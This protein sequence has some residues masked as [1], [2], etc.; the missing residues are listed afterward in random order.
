MSTQIWWQMSIFFVPAV[1]GREKRGQF[2]GWMQNWFGTFLKNIIFWIFY[3]W[4]NSV[5]VLLWIAIN[6]P[7]CFCNWNKRQAVWFNL[8]SLLSLIASPWTLWTPF[9]R[10]WWFWIGWIAR[11]WTPSQIDSCQCI[12]LTQIYWHSL[13]I[14]KIYYYIFT[15]HQP[16]RML[17]DQSFFYCS[18]SV[19]LNTHNNIL[20]YCAGTGIRH[21]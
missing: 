8:L 6:I 15:Q 10:L 14:D 5:C 21:T 9:E 4:L 16:T 13:S 3:D 20:Q 12:E 7:E 2:L 19:T 1:W 11:R 17:Q 18:F